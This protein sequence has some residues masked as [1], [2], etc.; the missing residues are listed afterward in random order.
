MTDDPFYLAFLK[1]LIPEIREYYHLIKQRYD[2]K[3]DEKE[4]EKKFTNIFN[5]TLNELDLPGSDEISS[6]DIINKYFNKNV[7]YH[8]KEELDNLLK[9]IPDKK[10]HLFIN[11]LRLNFLI[12]LSDQ[13]KSSILYTSRWKKLK[14]YYDYT[15]SDAF[16]NNIFN[17]NILQYYVPQVLTNE[18]TGTH[19]HNH[20]EFLI[21]DFLSVGYDKSNT[22]LILGS[23]GIGKTSFIKNFIR[24]SIESKSQNYTD[25]YIPIYFK[26]SED[27]FEDEFIKFFKEFIPGKQKVLL[28][29]DDLSEE[30]FE[31]KFNLIKQLVEEVKL[32]PL[33]TKQIYLVRLDK[34]E[35]L[36][37]FQ[38]FTKV[39]LQGFPSVEERDQF[40]SK[41]F[42][43]RKVDLDQILKKHSYKSLDDMIN[44]TIN[45][46]GINDL[47]LIKPINCWMLGKI[48]ADGPGLNNQDHS[49]IIFFYQEFIQILCDYLNI[50]KKKLRKI[51]QLYKYFKTYRRY[52]FVD[53]NFF[54][55]L[56]SEYMEFDNLDSTEKNGIT[57]F[58]SKTLYS[59]DSI[60][61][62]ALDYLNAESLV[63]SIY[64]EKKTL[65]NL[66]SLNSNSIKNFD[67]LIKICS[68]PGERKFSQLATL[69]LE[70]INHDTDL[71][72]LAANSLKLLKDSIPCS[73]TI[74]AY[75]S[76]KKEE[77]QE[78]QK[79]S[80]ILRLSENCKNFLIHRWISLYYLI[81]LNMQQHI[82]IDLIINLVRTS[83]YV[84][85]YVK[86]LSQLQFHDKD[87]S[88]LD[89]SSADLTDS[90]FTN[91]KLLNV[92]FNNT[93][94]N[95][96]VIQ[97][98]SIENCDMHFSNNNSL[99]N[100]ISSNKVNMI[101]SF[102][103]DSN[104]SSISWME[105]MIIDNLFI[106]CDLTHC[107]FMEVHFCGTNF[108][109]S[110]LTDTK[111]DTCIFENSNFM[112]CD[113]SY[114]DVGSKLNH[115]PKIINSIEKKNIDCYY[116][117]KLS[118]PLNEIWME[119]DLSTIV[120]KIDQHVETL[121]EVRFLG[122]IDRYDSEFFW[123]R[124]KTHNRILTHKDKSIL[125]LLSTRAYN[126]I[127]NNKNDTGLN[128]F[129]ISKYEKIK[130]ITI[131]YNDQILIILTTEPG[132]NKE[133]DLI[134]EIRK[135]ILHN[136]AQKDLIYNNKDDHEDYKEPLS[137]TEREKYV[138]FFSNLVEDNIDESETIRLMGICDYTG[139]FVKFVRNKSK[140]NQFM[141]NNQEIVNLFE[142]TAQ[143]WRFRQKLS[144]KIG[145][146]EYT[147]NIFERIIRIT[148]YIST[149][150]ILRMSLETY[151]DLDRLNQF[152]RK[153][154][155]NLH[156]KKIQIDEFLKSDTVSKKYSLSLIKQ[157]NPLIDCPY[158]NK[159]SDRR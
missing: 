12:D 82:D 2:D 111:M 6:N 94:L 135:I 3:S 45:R 87:I 139:S 109:K 153:I 88:N 93:I 18:Q 140:K 147:I 130:R 84:P 1:F 149:L 59:H 11:Y 30:N 143:R 101:N 117:T 57:K 120:K 62:I 53:G 43:H 97:N 91:S 124:T 114:F 105:S 148:M 86:I 68:I 83:E 151:D 7:R 136:G 116:F 44:S 33:H 50:K 155:K 41:Y 31:K 95:G 115:P 100:N 38:R 5:N 10:R 64:F 90:T 141:L 102:I 69:D 23:L 28:I 49:E 58:I 133:F 156:E 55:F 107:N 118:S 40:F 126:L 70:F 13:D 19:F 56:K 34:N 27:N 25:D 51:V 75:P 14:S 52:S 138:R 103:I 123:E 15:R 137:P 119:K 132:Y 144:D 157:V 54:Q 81:K 158:C 17:E 4:A 80:P 108:Y 104:L 145:L 20:A 26:T 35:N 96:V 131:T 37:H 152:I 146:T 129:V 16:Q 74:F 134:E 22:I 142:S 121:N 66:T 98:T 154:E 72:R 76:S 48:L 9:F 73:G 106:N 77:K 39:Y 29:L 127:E 125:R 78:D 60:L 99:N 36:G 79:D 61:Q 150:F 21:Q 112:S 42:E 65:L 32:N 122:F 67:S 85:S 113:L 47:D 71:E 110:D 92:N 8:K 89:L 24:E 63:E 46:L 128:K 159:R